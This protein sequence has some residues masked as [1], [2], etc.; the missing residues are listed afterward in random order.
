M[1]R[2]VRACHATC[3]G[4]DRASPFTGGRV[5]HA[6][7]PWPE[8]LGKAKILGFVWLR[9]PCCRRTRRFGDCRRGPLATR[10]LLRFLAAGHPALERA[11][12]PDGRWPVGSARRPNR[13]PAAGDAPEGEPD[14]EDA[15][16]EEPSSL[17]APLH[18]KVPRLRPA[19]SPARRRSRRP[20]VPRSVVVTPRSR[21]PVSSVPSRATPD[22]RRNRASR[23]V[24]LLGAAHTPEGVLRSAPPASPLG[25]RS[26][27]AHSTRRQIAQSGREPRRVPPWLPITQSLGGQVLLRGPVPTVPFY[28]NSLATGIGS[29]QT[30]IASIAKRN[31]TE[32]PMT[33]RR[34]HADVGFV[35]YADE[36]RDPP[37]GWGPS[38]APECPRARRT[39]APPAYLPL[40]RG[41]SP[42]PNT[43]VSGEA[44]ADG[45]ARSDGSNVSMFTSKSV[46]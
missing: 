15:G 3:V 23:R 2:R 25:T 13:G 40:A 20:P 33:T 42:S 34:S 45:S 8:S 43:E 14:D 29:G 10:R 18:P 9:G 12:V 1:D 37:R 38:R 21:A 35:G 39:E 32:V 11:K 46:S 44:Q 24:G 26:T 31:G 28:G 16:S 5:P 17:P 19:A 6:V 4:E 30:D 22:S 7:S 36:P 41:V 27:S